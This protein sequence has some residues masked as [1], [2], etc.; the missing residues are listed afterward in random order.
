MIRIVNILKLLYPYL[1]IQIL[2]GVL[3]SFFGANCLKVEKLEVK[4]AVLSVLVNLLPMPFI[5]RRYRIPF[6]SDLKLNFRNPVKASLLGI[7]LGFF[8]VCSI[9]LLLNFV[10]TAITLTIAHTRISLLL[11]WFVLVLLMAF[12]EEFFFRYAWFKII[13]PDDLSGLCSAA[14]FT[15]MHLGN[16]D[17]SIVAVVNVFLFG[18]V[19]WF[20]FRQRQ[21][22]IFS[23]FL[24]AAW[25]Y[26]CG[27]ILGTRVS[28]VEIPYS[29]FRTNMEGT[30]LLTG[31]QFGL[32]GSLV[33]VIFQLLILLLIKLLMI[34]PDKQKNRYK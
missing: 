30:P 29:I 28:G 3:I 21:N 26:S 27:F 25:N 14:V 10:N 7:T 13:G 23:T 18:L 17:I 22:L 2:A 24:H 6:A 4:T 12:S 31:G 34:V 11:E 8:S 19:T 33:T 5:L 1:G 15:L 20:L 32:E 9:L 16:P